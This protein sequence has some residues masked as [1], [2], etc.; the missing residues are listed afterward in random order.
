MQLRKALQEFKRNIHGVS[1]V[2]VIVLSLVILTVV[3]ANVVLWNYEMN[4]LDWDRTKEDLEITRVVPVLNSS[5]TSTTKEYTI[6]TGSLLN[7]SYRETQIID[8]SSETF[9]EGTGL[10]IDINGTFR[11]DF[12]AHSPSSIR[13]VEVQLVYRASDTEET[14]YLRA[15]NWSASTYSDIG[16]N[17]TSG[18]TATENWDIYSVNL[19]DDWSSYVSIDGSMCIQLRDSAAD[20]NP[21]IINIDFLAVRVLMEGA[22]LAFRYQGSVTCHLIS[23]WVDNSTYHRRHVVSIYINAGEPLVYTSTEIHLPE[24]SYIVKVTTERGNVFVYTVD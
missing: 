19:T 24:E 1:S 8:G 5:W 3:F 9:R 23:I 11:I 18:H 10:R 20:A 14:F 21:T 4:Q 12:A 15:Y 7:G 16:F 6:R 13:S 2:I 22:E 17:N